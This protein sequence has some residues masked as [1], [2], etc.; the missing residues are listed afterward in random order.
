MKKIG[1]VMPVT[2]NPANIA[3]KEFVVCKKPLAWVFNPVRPGGV[4]N[5][6]PPL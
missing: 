2:I 5:M 1:K 3:N 4:H 6:R